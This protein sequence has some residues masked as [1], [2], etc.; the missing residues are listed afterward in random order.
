[1]GER[2]KDRQ[3][4]RDREIDRERGG[5]G[6]ETKRERGG[7]ERGPNLYKRRER[8]RMY[9]TK[10]HLNFQQVLL[11]RSFIYNKFSTLPLMNWHSSLMDIFF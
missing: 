2:E 4:M 11:Y 6:G 1:M 5:D 10:C 7:R 9:S 3:R 8:E